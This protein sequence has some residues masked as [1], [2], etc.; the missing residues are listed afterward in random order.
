MRAVRGWGKVV[1][2][3]VGHGKDLNAYPTEGE[4]WRAVG[5]GGGGI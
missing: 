5:R 1:Q 4:P 2:G 3:I